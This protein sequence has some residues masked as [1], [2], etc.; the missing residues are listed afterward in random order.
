MIDVSAPLAAALLA[1]FLGSAHCLAMC[2]GISGMVAV[3]AGAHALSTQ[4]PLAI[5][6]NAGR[7]FSYA[8]LG[9]AVAAL[10]EA[11]VAAVP[12]LAGPVRLVSGLLIALVGLQVAFRWRLL[13]PLENAGAKL[14][15]RIVPLARRLLPASTAPRAF[16]LGLLWGF[17]PC[18]LVYSALLIAAATANVAAGTATMLAFG[19]GTSPA[20]IATGIGA[21]TLS[22]IV[23]KARVTAGLLI[24]ALGLLTIALPIASLTGTNGHGGH[25]MP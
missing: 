5:A 20:M 4:L 25:S 12:R 18:G 8:L 11:A 16:G 9:A 2:A 7:I 17:L 10:G 15:Q 13:A 3:G 1:G 23:G 22:R 14:W 24:V 21:L 6:Y 19:L